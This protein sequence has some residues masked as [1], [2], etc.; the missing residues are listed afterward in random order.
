MFLKNHLHLYLCESCWFDRNTESRVVRELRLCLLPMFDMEPVVRN[1]LSFHCHCVVC[2]H[3]H[4]HTH[5]TAVAF[6][7]GL[8]N[9]VVFCQTFQEAFFSRSDLSGL[10]PLKHTALIELDLMS[11]SNQSFAYFLNTCSC[12][13]WEWF[14]CDCPELWRQIQQTGKIWAYSW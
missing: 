14:I 4:T 8:S 10:F 12:S 6:I 3:T 7:T 5:T 11:A 2:P 9:I 1:R 13:D